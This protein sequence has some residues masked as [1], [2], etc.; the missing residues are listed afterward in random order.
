MGGGGWGE[1]V[2][3]GVRGVGGGRGQG[4]ARVRRVQ[5]NTWGHK[6]WG[7]QGKLPP[8]AALLFGHHTLFCCTA[9]TP[10]SQAHLAKECEDQ[11]GQEE[12]EEE[13]EEGARR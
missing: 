11:Q 10:D 8:C 2:G 7:V 4:G 3:R 6:R 12:D 1:V 5:I 9:H 13:E